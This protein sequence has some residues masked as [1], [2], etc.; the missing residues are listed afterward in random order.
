MRMWRS[1]FGTVWRFLAA[2]H[3]EL[4]FFA[5]VVLLAV[6]A[7]WMYPPAGLITAGGLLVW[8]SI[9]TRHFPIVFRAP[10]EPR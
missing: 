1:M 4:L 10:K 7:W 8:I 3:Q 2:A 9:P 5:G 6:G